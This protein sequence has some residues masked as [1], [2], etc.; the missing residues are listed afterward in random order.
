[1][2]WK[3]TQL[4]SCKWCGKKID[5]T[6]NKRLRC[7]CSAACR[8]KVNQINAQPQ[9]S[10]WQRERNDKRASTPS[11][12]K[13]KCGICNRWYKRVGFH[14]WIRHGVLARDYRREMGLPLSIGIMTDKDR[15]HM[16]KLAYQYDMPKQVIRTGKKTRYV[17]GDP[18]AKKGYATAGRKAESSD[19]F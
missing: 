8:M 7:F 3:V 9:R 2:T 12:D 5:R 6:L 1:M 18:R 17:K 4:E 19:Y 15:A 16:S 13:K 10:K 14:V 11:P